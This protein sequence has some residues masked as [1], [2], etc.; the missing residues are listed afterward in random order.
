[1]II[2]PSNVATK[3]AGLVISYTLGA[4]GSGGYNTSRGSTGGTTTVTFE[5]KT[6]IAYGGEG[7]YYNTNTA[8]AGGTAT[9]GMVN[10]AGGSGGY[11]SGDHGGGGGGGIGGA[12]GSNYGDIGAGGTGAQAISVSMLKSAV[13]EASV[14]WTGPGSG[15]TGSASDTNHGGDATGF[16]CG[17]GGAS[18]YGGNGG[19]GLNGGGGG[20][21]AGYSIARTGGTGGGGAVV[22]K[23]GGV[24]P[25]YVVLTSGDSYTVPDDSTLEKL[26]AI[27][28]GG[29]GAGAT[30]SDNSAGG[31]GGAGGMSYWNSAGATLLTVNTY[32][33]SSVYSSNSAA[34]WE[35][36]NNDS[37]N[38]STNGAQ[39]GTD[40]GG[41]QWIKT[42]LGGQYHVDHI[43]IGYDHMQNLPGGW[44]T[45]YTENVDVQG[46]NNNSTW[47]T[48][49][50]TPDYGDTGSTD[51]L[52]E[53]PIDGDWS[54]LR[55]SRSGDYLCVLEFEVWVT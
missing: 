9:G 49:A 25:T 28:G 38:G 54:Y 41:T 51:G 29:G 45:Y 55:L 10:I 19:S 42:S 46:S 50:T 4:A 12:N 3:T 23:L 52:Y 24:T 21:A 17:G 7:G 36:M 48:I 11:S 32:S 5:D 35:Y 34:T 31:A 27:G 16:G 40:Y 15:S 53:I 20:G 43:V 37:A 13:E 6:L 8:A 39:T 22:A 14:S 2:I 1:M 26:W 18:Y 47:T 44:G 30:N 33:Q